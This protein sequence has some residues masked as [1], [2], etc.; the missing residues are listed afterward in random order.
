M[1]CIHLILFY[2][3]LLVGAGSVWVLIRIHGTSDGPGAL[4]FYIGAV[5]GLGGALSLFTARRRRS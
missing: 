1:G 5:F 2:G 3:C 4:F